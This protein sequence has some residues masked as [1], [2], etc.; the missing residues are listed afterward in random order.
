MSSPRRLK[1]YTA[2]SKSAL[3]SENA[4]IAGKSVDQTF[5]NSCGLFVKVSISSDARWARASKAL[6]VACSSTPC[7]CPSLLCSK[8]ITITSLPLSCNHSNSGSS[9]MTARTRGLMMSTAGLTKLPDVRAV[10]GIDE[11][12]LQTAFNNSARRVFAVILG[13]ATGLVEVILFGPPSPVTRA[14]TLTSETCSRVG[15]SS[16]KDVS[17][18]GLMPAFV[19]RSCWMRRGASTALCCLRSS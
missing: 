4:E 2:L 11:A 15:A 16:F 9:C 3:A 13:P 14:L 17:A 5:Q 8:S 10:T 12:G 6:A 18:S 1:K 7:L 19:L